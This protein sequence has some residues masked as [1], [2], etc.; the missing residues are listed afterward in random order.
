MRNSMLWGTE[1]LKKLEILLLFHTI[2]KILVK[3]S[4]IEVKII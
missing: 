1:I 3:P 2:L 4:K